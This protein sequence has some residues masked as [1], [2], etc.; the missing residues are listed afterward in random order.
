MHPTECDS[1]NIKAVLTALRLTSNEER[2]EPDKH[3][4]NVLWKGQSKC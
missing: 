2:S 1:H 3:I 4:I